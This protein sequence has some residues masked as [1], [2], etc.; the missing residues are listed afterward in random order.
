M[1]RSLSARENMLATKMVIDSD[2]RAAT[3]LWNEVG[4]LPAMTQFHQLLGYRQTIMSWSW[5][6]IE[7][8]PVDELELLKA[9][10]LPN[11]IL[12]DSSRA[13]EESLMQ[14]SDLS[15]R[16]GLGDG[17]PAAA[18]VGMKDGYYPEAKTG[19]QINSAGYVHLGSRFYL[20]AIMTS[21]N[22]NETYGINTADTIAKLIWQTL[23][24]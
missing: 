19:W 4:Q 22:P 6:E 7:T 8:T 12:T 3:V 20:A 14:S 24:P 18:T 15:T 10:A 9:I 13:Y 21:H 23:R 2:N 17:P 5:G 11:A 1:H 16:F